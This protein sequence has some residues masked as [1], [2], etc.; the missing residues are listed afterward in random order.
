MS[1]RPTLLASPLAGFL[2]R[3]ALAPRQ[4]HAALTLWPLVLRDL[5]D[6]APA[7]DGVPKIV[8]LADAL[9]AGTGRV[10]ELGPGGIG[11]QLRVENDGDA[12]LLVLFGEELCCGTQQR[13]ANAS[14]LVRGRSSLVI[15]VACVGREPWVRRPGARFVAGGAVASHALRRKMAPKVATAR[16]ALGRFVADQREVW[17]EVAAR[18]ARARVYDAAAGFAELR[19]AHVVATDALAAHFHPVA[20]QLGFVA[21]IG[22]AIAGLEAVGRPDVFARLFPSLLRAYAIDAIEEIAHAPS[23]EREA[24]YRGPEPFVTA[25]ASVPAGAGPSL[26]IGDDLRFDAAGLRGCALVAGDVI[27]ATAFPV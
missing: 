20:G 8:P 3:L 24:R 1:L 10:V 18:L 16:A 14:F 6:S 12:A 23:Q 25:L 7:P 13:V 27:H 15:D 19:A 11:P 17:D 4:G 2:S 22:D 21:A 26:G 9:D 5:A